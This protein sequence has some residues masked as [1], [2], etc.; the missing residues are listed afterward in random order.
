MTRPLLK[1]IDG[2]QRRFPWAL[3]GLS[4]AVLIGFP[5]G[6]VVFSLLLGMIGGPLAVLAALVAAGWLASRWPFFRKGK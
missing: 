4:L 5:V 1:D 2:R 6:V 3:V